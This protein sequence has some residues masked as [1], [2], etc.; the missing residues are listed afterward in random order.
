MNHSTM[1]THVTQ[2][3]RLLFQLKKQELMELL[4]RSQNPADALSELHMRLLKLCTRHFSCLAAKQ[5]WSHACACI[6]LKLFQC[7]RQ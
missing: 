7:C 1:S 5:L 3:P 6:L 4:R 2:D